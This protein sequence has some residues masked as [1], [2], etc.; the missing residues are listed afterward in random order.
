[1]SSLLVEAEFAGI[2]NG[3]TDITDDL[4]DQ[5]Q[6]LSWGLGGIG[7]TDRCAMTGQ[8]TFQMNNGVGN[9]AGLQ[10]Y[11]S[12]SNANARGGWALGIRVRLTITA[13]GTPYVRAIYFIDDIEPKAGVFGDLV[14]DVTASS[15]LDNAA[16]TTVAGLQ[17]QTSQRGDQLVSALLALVPV[18]PVSVE[19]DTGQDTYPFALYGLSPSSTVLQALA[20]I[21]VSGLD[22]IYERGDGTLVYESRTARARKSTNIATFVDTGDLSGLQAS[23]QRGYI[24][25]QV[26]LT[27]HPLELDA[28]PV[29]LY[30]LHT[31]TGSPAIVSPG[32]T[33][34]LLGV[35]VDPN[36]NAQT[37]GGFDFVDPEAVTDYAANAAADGSGADLTSRIA[38]A[39]T[40]SGAGVTFAVTNNGSVDAYVTQ[41]QCRGKGIYNY[42]QAIGTAS[43]ADSQALF[44]QRLLAMDLR[45]QFDP[46]FAFEAALYLV[47][48]YKDATTQVPHVEVF[49]PADNEVL[50]ETC[51]LRDIS[52]R[53]GIVEGVTGVSLGSGVVTKGFF[54]NSV[55][56]TIDERGNATFIWSCAPADQTSYWLLEVVGNSELDETT[57][58]GFGRISGHA[59]VAHADTH[60]DTA[61]AD[62]AHGDSHGDAA[63]VDNAHADSTHTDTAFVDVAHGDSHGDTA[64]SDAGHGD[65]SH[66]DSHSDVAHND[67]HTDTAHVDSH[68][69]SH[70]DSS[71]ADSP[72]VDS[73][74]DHTDIPLDHDDL[75][76]FVEHVDV[77]HGDVAHDDSHSDSAH[78]DTHVDTAHADTTSSRAH[79]DTAHGDAA[80]VDTHSD[81]AHADTA[82]VDAGHADAVHTDTAHVDVAHSD[83]AH[84]DTAHV[85][86]HAD[87]AHG[88]A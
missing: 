57:V 2:G 83:S 17:V 85:D 50:M 65:I 32:A 74:G 49:V 46:G 43:D 1:M 44:G 18:Q 6:N 9:S 24:A 81:V 58:L 80:H 47:H 14:V 69:D 52:D 72:H 55:D 77:A 51:L 22:L 76:S 56:M 64:H 15:W 62:V 54:I 68:S 40:F 31:S 26:Q 11:Y 13:N 78:A 82:H 48:L 53:I 16:T 34:S 71:H 67:S 38:V 39:A 7:A 25:N 66:Q 23:R 21:A 37:I 30:S 36:Q 20:N 10:G 86:V 45:Y 88:D 27:V 75:T 33:L 3:W 73:H 41:L 60:V 87:T 70:T 29:V 42:Q 59:D 8:W 12:P 35:F 63:H 28:A 5:P 79:T 61:H 19:L 4:T 84:T